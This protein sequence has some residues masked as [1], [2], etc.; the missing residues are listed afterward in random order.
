V[1]VYA[2]WSSSYLPSAGDQF[3]SLTATSKTL[4]PERFVNREVGVK[5]EPLRDLMLTGALYRLTRTNTSAPDPQNPGVVVQT[6]SQR[7]QGFELT[8]SGAVTRGWDIAGA[9]TS[10]SARIVRRTVAARAG[11]TAPLVPRER[12]S[13]WNRVQVAPNVA[14]GAGLVHQSDAFAAIDNAVTLPG[15]WRVDAALFLTRLRDITAQLNIENVTNVFYYP[16]SQGNNNIMPGQP[17][18]LRLSFLT[19]LP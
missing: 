11:A 12:L 4:E 1:S 8:A 2:S 15:F 19:A 6:G 16:T 3:S 10:Q 9:Y 14:L 7:S 17:R 18:T 13:L 5:W